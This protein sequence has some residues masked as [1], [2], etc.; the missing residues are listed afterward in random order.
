V[1]LRLKADFW[2]WLIAIIETLLLSRLVLKLFAARPDHPVVE[3][4]FAFT[5][6]LVLPLQTLDANQPRFG[7]VLEF[8]TLATVC[9]VV[10]GY[11]AVR[12]GQRYWS[13]RRNTM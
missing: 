2:V 5:S 9:L 4:L 1:N 11:F 10:L 6:L 7:A 3:A 13:A 12:R 8:S